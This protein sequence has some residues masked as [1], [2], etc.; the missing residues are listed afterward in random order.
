MTDL[1]FGEL[2]Q[3]LC[4]EFFFYADQRGRS[5]LDSIML[6]YWRARGP[7]LAG[8]AANLPGS[9]FLITT[10]DAGQLPELVRKGLTVADHVIIRHD[11]Y[12]PI[13]GLVLDAHPADF[14]GFGEID[15]IEQHRDHLPQTRSL[16]HFQS[17]PPREEVA[18]FIDWLCGDG[19][20]W[21][22]NGLVTYAPILVP[23]QVDVGLLNE[24]VNLSSL[25]ASAG[26][27]PQ[28]NRLI[29]PQTAAALADLK[30][31]Y[32]DSISADLFSAFRAEE[33]DTIDAF[34]R[35]LVALLA[36]VSSEVSSPQ[37]S[38]EVE[39]LS[40][41]LEDETK[42]LESA[43]ARHSRTQPWR[44]LRAEILALSALVFFYI[45]VPVPGIAGLT[46]GAL[47]LVNTIKD[48]LQDSF[49]LKENPVFFLAKLGQLIEKQDRW[50]QEVER[51]GRGRR[52]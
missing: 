34:R 50:S 46:A 10:D 21:L 7:A 24:N 17:G 3:E 5:Y 30:V 4:Q 40:I 45:G 15:W 35:H 9:K 36:R 31:P 20:A 32:L 2:H 14:A 23:G 52:I 44:R 28:S 29:N 49:S 25:F 27:L 18:P 1:N 16:P 41:E 6:M 43:I 8:C 47:D 19:R 51:S 37:F 42:R 33:S 11:A 12:L 13:R 48:D 26:V 22:Q 39:K 38:Q